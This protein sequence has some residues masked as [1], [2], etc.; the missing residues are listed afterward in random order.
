EA[1]LS[2]GRLP[3]WREHPG[4]DAGRAGRRPLAL[5]DADSRTISSRAPGAG[6]PDH[7]GAYD[8]HVVPALRFVAHNAALPA[9][10]ALQPPCAGITRIRFR[11]SAALQPPSQP[12]VGSR[13]TAIV[14]R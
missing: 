14:V 9:A 4:R 7:A 3:D 2:P 1:L 6:E 8:D 12:L 13:C 11:R 10:D 5:E